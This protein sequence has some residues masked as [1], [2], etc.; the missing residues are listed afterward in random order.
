MQLRVCKGVQVMLSILDLRLHS[1]LTLHF[2]AKAQSR[3]QHTEDKWKC[4]NA[5]DQAAGAI[6]GAFEL[7]LVAPEPDFLQRPSSAV[8]CKAN[9]VAL[10]C[11]SLYLQL[12]QPQ[13]P[14]RCAAGPVA[15]C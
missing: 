12:D 1:M 5:V 4:R 15:P 3:Q 13:Q 6:T 10:V 11:F 9:R 2:H 14:L 8:H 7:A